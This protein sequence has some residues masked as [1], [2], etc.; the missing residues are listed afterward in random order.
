MKQYITYQDK[1]NE[2]RLDLSHPKN[3]NFS[4]VIVEGDSDIRL[5]RK[6]FNL[7]HCK[8]ETIPGGNY[9]VEECVSTFIT[10]YPLVIG[11]RDADFLHLES[12]PYKKTNMFLT[13]Y[14]DMEMMIL[15][16]DDVFSA[17]LFEF[18]TLPQELHQKKREDILLA[19]EH[20]SFV[21]WLNV[22]ENLAIPVAS[23]NS[24]NYPNTSDIEEFLTSILEKSTA[25]KITAIELILEK[26][27]VL[28]A[29]KPHLMQLCNGH[30]FLMAL[31]DIV[32]QSQ[33][34]KN[35]SDESIAS[36]C[37][38]AYTRAHFQKTSLYEQ[39]VSWSESQGCTLF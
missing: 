22:K 19:I 2:L 15:S 20:I 31:S 29:L 1:L 27:N 38:V 34:G 3:K 28:K 12:Q 8:V 5:F 39:I 37:R 9:K 26:F 16:E 6:L 21:K 24:R 36:T 23:V 14:H 10:T 25:P 30:D 17:L 13:D 4:F 11:I 33:K 35:V 7:N 32:K 18:T